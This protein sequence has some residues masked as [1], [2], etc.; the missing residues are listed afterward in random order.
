[1]RDHLIRS[2]LERTVE[3]SPDGMRQRLEVQ[4]R[5][6][7]PIAEIVRTP[8]YGGA[9]TSPPDEE[10]A[11]SGVHSLT[12]PTFDKPVVFLDTSLQPDALERQVGHGFVNDLECTWVER[13]CL[14]YEAELRHRTD[15]DR[16][17]TVNILCFYQA[18]ALELR[19]RLGAPL[20]PR[21][22][23][24]S[25][26][27]IAPIDRLQGQESDLVFV[28]FSRVNPTPGPH[29]G[30]WLQ[31]LRRLNVACTRAHRALVLVGHRQMLSRLRATPAAADFYRHLNS[32][33]DESDDYLLMTD[34]LR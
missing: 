27:K 26:D 13:A 33:F 6:I 24:L 5:M 1:M 16:P 28:T 29:F 19:R 9:Y 2:L 20:Y 31:D 8:I 34:F 23:R 15:L 7:A 22:R 21:F 11:R 14:R 12:T 30:R 3:R 17:V 25:F 32:L 10:L 18:Q 4:R